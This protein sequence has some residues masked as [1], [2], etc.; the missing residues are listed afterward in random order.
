MLSPQT[1]DRLGTGHCEGTISTRS[2]GGLRSEHVGVKKRNTLEA[3][4]IWTYL[5]KKFHRWPK[6]KWKGALGM[7][8]RAF[9]SRIRWRTFEK[10]DHVKCSKRCGKW[11]AHMLWE[12]NWS[13]FKRLIQLNL[14]WFKVSSLIEEEHASEFCRSNSII[15]KNTYIK[16]FIEAVFATARNNLLLSKRKI[17]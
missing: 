10:I 9:F 17:G 2:V 16:M 12:Y 1:E 3:Q 8:V 15:Y 5:Q 4:W 11:G 13:T 6:I 7:W 14:L